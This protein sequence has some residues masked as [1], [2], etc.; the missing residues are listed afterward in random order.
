MSYG[1]KIT[2]LITFD[3]DAHY[4]PAKN[5]KDE[6]LACEN[7][8]YL[9]ILNS[10]NDLQSIDKSDWTVGAIRENSNIRFYSNYPMQ[11]ISVYDLQGRLVAEKMNINSTVDFIQSI[12]SQMYIAKVVTDRGV[13]YLKVIR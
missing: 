10:T 4:T 2:G 11:S 12:K 9:L 8:F 3:Y 7:R 13:K 1:S 5:D 6:T